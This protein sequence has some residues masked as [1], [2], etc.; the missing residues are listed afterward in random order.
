MPDEAVYLAEYLLYFFGIQLLILWIVLPITVYGIKRRVEDSAVRLQQIIDELLLI[1]G[2][3]DGGKLTTLALDRAR[4]ATATP[5]VQDLAVQDLAVQD[6]A[7][8]DLAVQELATVRIEPE[9]L[10]PPAKEAEPPAAKADDVDKTD[11]EPTPEEPPKAVAT[12]HFNGSAAETDTAQA[13]QKAEDTSDDKKAE[14]APKKNG[15]ARPDAGEP[16]ILMAEEAL[17]DDADAV[18][19]P[20]ETEHKIDFEADMDVDGDFA[21]DSQ[22]YED[23]SLHYLDEENDPSAD[24]IEATRPK[25]PKEGE[26]AG[27][28]ISEDPEGFYVYRGRRYEKLIDAMRQQH[29]DTTR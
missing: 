7:V 16:D 11:P 17:A 20:V 3:M 10:A 6:L 28:E 24:L 14:L 25:P 5:A 23:D 26:A 22:D 29:I 12:T 18:R 15:K 8:Q 19:E 4:E 9:P 2:A 27:D 21:D 13:D 1:R